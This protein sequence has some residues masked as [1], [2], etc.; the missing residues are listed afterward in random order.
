[1]RFTDIFAK[2]ACAGDLAQLPDS[3]LVLGH[4]QDAVRATPVINTVIT[5]NTSYYGASADLIRASST[6][7]LEQAV[8]SRQHR[9]HDLLSSQLGSSVTAY[10]KLNTDPNAALSDIL[11]KVNSVRSPV[12]Q[13]GG[14]PFGH[15]LHRLHH[16]G[17][18]MG[19][20]SPELSTQPDHRLPG[21]VI[22][23][24]LFTVGGVS[25]VDLYGGVRIRP[26]G[27]A[28]SAKMPPLIDLKRR[29]DGAQQQQLSVRDRPGP[30]ASPCSAATPRP[31][32][33]ASKSSSVWWSPPATAGDPSLRHRQGL[34]WGK[35]TT[36]SRQR[37]RPQA[38]VLA[39]NA[40][41]QPTPSAS[42]RCAGAA[43]EPE[44]QHAEHHAGERPV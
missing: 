27:V 1:M 8:L 11:A 42:P 44:A 28:G 22:K 35:A 4:L 2:T 19:F 37:Q 13:R 31:R 38:V 23:P 16:G 20:T 24:Q 21:R 10:M 14:R 17:A 18:H 33:A 12:A 7:P 6:Q 15:L 39:I 9:L 41:R 3:L 29:D 36:S 26:A 5:V 30:P 34:P 32:S 40:A 43:A 25:K